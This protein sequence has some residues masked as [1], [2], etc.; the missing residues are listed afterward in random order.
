MINIAIGIYPKQLDL[1]P[2]CNIDIEDDIIGNYFDI[3]IGWLWFELT[4]SI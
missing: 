1:L 3:N 4:I 2:Y